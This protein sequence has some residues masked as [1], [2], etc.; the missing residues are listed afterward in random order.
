MLIRSLG[1][2]RPKY[3]KDAHEDGE[4][5][6]PAKIFLF[7]SLLNILRKFRLNRTLQPWIRST[8]LHQYKSS[9]NDQS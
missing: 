8:D 2:M 9:Q 6:E 5:I 1:P 7:Y 3:P 4:L